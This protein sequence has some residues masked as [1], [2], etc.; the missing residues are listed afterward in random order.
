MVG[1][2]KPLVLA[3]TKALL[4]SVLTSVQLGDGD[5]VDA[6]IISSRS[7]LQ[8]PAG[9]LRFSK[10]STDVM[11]P[12]LASLDDSALIGVSTSVLKKLSATSG[13]LVNFSLRISQLFLFGFRE[14]D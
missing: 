1:R 9:I 11:D 5:S 2:R 12:K 8:L 14:N 7:S 6:A 3:S 10:T 13:S 4:N